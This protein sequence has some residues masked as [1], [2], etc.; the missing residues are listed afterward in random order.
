[1]D[2]LHF[3]SEVVIN[4]VLNGQGSQEPTKAQESEKT[5]TSDQQTRAQDGGV[6][7][8]VDNQMN[9][10]EGEK[11]MQKSVKSVLWQSPLMQNYVHNALKYDRFLDKKA[12]GHL[13]EH[14]GISSDA[15][16]YY[17]D[18]AYPLRGRFTLTD[19]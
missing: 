17:L 13:A 18:A 15:L 7:G 6:A 8:L 5:I 4:D 12:I 11:T 9:K 2:D 19:E 10:Q 3:F 14:I 16:C 1:M